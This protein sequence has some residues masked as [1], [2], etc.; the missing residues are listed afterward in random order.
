MK[1]TPTC[2][3][4]PATVALLSMVVTFGQTWPAA[5]AAPREHLDEM[6]TVYTATGSAD[7]LAGRGAKCIATTLSSGQQGGQVILSSDRASETIVANNALE[8]Q[9]G[10]LKWRMRARML[11]EAKDG[12]FRIQ[13]TN[14][15]RDYGAPTGWDVVGKWPMSGWQK[16]AAALQTT[17]DDVALCVQK[18]SSANW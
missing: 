13:Q 11:F 2:S 12:R 7:D 6:T 10:M 18:T 16:A 14:I 5:A 8:Y 15:Q 4:R 9:D 17:S 3:P 1:A